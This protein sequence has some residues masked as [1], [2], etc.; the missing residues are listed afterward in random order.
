MKYL[1][2]DQK[3]SGVYDDTQNLRTKLELEEKP[4]GF[5]TLLSSG[6]A[7]TVTFYLPAYHYFVLC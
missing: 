7:G 1:F 2:R 4:D 5:N 6:A 3:L